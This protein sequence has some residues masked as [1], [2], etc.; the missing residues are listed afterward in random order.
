MTADMPPARRVAFAGMSNVSFLTL[1]IIGVLVSLTLVF[2]MF[3]V[4]LL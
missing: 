1:F 3:G 2:V 4:A